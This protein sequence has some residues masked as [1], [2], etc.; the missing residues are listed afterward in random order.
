MTRVMKQVEHENNAYK[1][2]TAHLKGNFTPRS[3][4]LIAG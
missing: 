3:L 2:R 1:K 4:S